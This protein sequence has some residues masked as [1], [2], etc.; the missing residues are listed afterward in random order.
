MTDVDNNRRNAT[1]SWSGY[2]H[3]GKVGILVALREIHRLLTINSGD[4]LTG[5]KIHYEIGEDFDIIN[6]SG[7]IISRHQV[8][9]NKN[10]NGRKAHYT[11]AIN[12]F[13]LNGLNEDTQ[14]F[15]HVVEKV[16]DWETSGAKI[17][18][19]KKRVVLYPFDESHF[20]CPLFEDEVSILKSHSLI[21]L[22]KILKIFELEKVTDE[23][24]EII[25]NCL[26]EE[27]RKEHIK[28]VP[29][30][31]LLFSDILNIILTGL[32]ER[33]SLRNI[34]RLRESFSA[35]YVEYKFELFDFDYSEHEAKVDEIVKNIYI[36]DNENFKLFLQFVHL[37]RPDFLKHWNLCETGINEVFF[38]CLYKIKNSDFCNDK[39]GYYH[40]LVSY[41]LT[42]I[43]S[44]KEL[45]IIKNIKQNPLISQITFEKGNI[46]NRHINSEVFELIT[47]VKK[48]EI[49]HKK[50]PY[51]LKNNNYVGLEDI[52]L[53]PKDVKLITLEK[54][55]EELN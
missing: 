46:I 10:T 6:N 16:I 8:K 37:D 27:L 14:C 43:N 42:T 33:E 26:D 24:Y 5:W 12:D 54:A 17:N 28:S 36:L 29:K 18:E 1:A 2:L 3:Q 15:F 49:S 25:M 9:A 51:V 41:L 55:I 50:I 32:P 35:C 48:Y 44:T 31:I 23:I 30:P 40:N 45:N 21:E 39:L 20:F 52:Y 22:K 4:S 19:D 53:N 11:K 47:Q 7:C 34:I 38:D 13:D